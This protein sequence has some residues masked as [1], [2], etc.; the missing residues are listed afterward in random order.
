MNRVRRLDYF[1]FCWVV[2][3]VA[4]PRKMARSRNA[5]FHP[6]HS[7]PAE[8]F[9]SPPRLV[10]NHGRLSRAGWIIVAFETSPD[11]SSRFRSFAVT[12]PTV[13]IVSRN[14]RSS[15][16]RSTF[17]ITL[18]VSFSFFFQEVDRSDGNEQK[19]KKREGSLRRWAIKIGVV[20][21]WGCAF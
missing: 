14:A 1:A 11:D 8:R 5:V 21:N 9:V 20:E 10:Q 12:V 18:R 4:S 2:G 15:D 7:S 19:Q 3:G 6:F 17:E 16:R 13:P